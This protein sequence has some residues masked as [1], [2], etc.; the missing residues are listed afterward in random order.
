GSGEEG[1]VKHFVEAG[2]QADALSTLRS[3]VDETERQAQWQRLPTLLAAEGRL[4]DTMQLEDTD[5][6]RLPNQIDLAEIELGDGIAPDPAAARRPL[7]RA[8][9]R[10]RARAGRGAAGRL[11]ERAVAR[12]D[13]RLCAKASRMVLQL[14]AAA[15]RL[16]PD[17]PLITRSHD[18]HATANDLRG[19]AQV[20]L[21]HAAAAWRDEDV[22]TA[23]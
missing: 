12:G 10:G 9:A 21:A 18:W 11:L 7:D 13:A 23:R 14:E 22:E 5:P 1:A 16:P 20:A 15:G 8:L 4:L 3:L 19:Q 6:L 2:L 17:D